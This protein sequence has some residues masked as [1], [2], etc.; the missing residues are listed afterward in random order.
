MVIRH[1]EPDSPAAAL[2]IRAG[3]DLVSINGN[4]IRDV[5]DY[6]FYVAD[7]EIE[8]VIAPPSGGAPKRLRAQLEPGQDLGLSLDA[9]KTRLCG[10][11]CVFCFIDQ[12]PKGM[13]QTLYVKDED[14]RLSFLHGNFVTLTN[15]K[16]SEIERVITQ[17]LSPLYVSVHSTNAETRQRLLR[18]RR[19]CDILAVID[20]LI[21]GGITLHTQVVLCPGFNDGADLDAT[22]DDLVGRWPG[23]QSLA[24]VP[25]G[26]TDHREGLLPVLDPFTVEDARR[27]LDQSVPRQKRYRRE[28]GATFLYLA[29]ELYRLLGVDPP[30]VSQYDGYPQLENGIGMT[31]HF[32][33]RLRRTRRLFPEAAKRGERRFTLVTGSLFEPILRPAFEEALART[34]EAVEVQVIGCANRFFGSS[35]TVA[36][37]LTGS[38]IASGIDGRDLGDRVYFP[39]ATLNDDG[40]F[41]DDMRPE[42]LERRFAVPF[43]PG[44]F[45]T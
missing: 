38:D 13:R 42:D 37:L 19:D 36:G 10:N 45:R 16:D 27:L 44:V 28:I 33:T 15:M 40:I 12:V 2:G 14:Y 8:I 17:R 35:V 23:V 26:L 18:P 1:I 11:E 31:R 9:M 6:H 32:L 21:E 41:L 39:P 5:L 20:R 24:V 22:I 43:Q 30:P 3:E 7:G 25:L 4:R 34:K 29:D